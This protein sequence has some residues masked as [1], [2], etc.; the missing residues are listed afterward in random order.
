MNTEKAYRDIGAA[1]VK[2]VIANNYFPGTIETAI[3]ERPMGRG[4][5][6]YVNNCHVPTALWSFP[7]LELIKKIAWH[8]RY[9]EREEKLVKEQKRKAKIRTGV[10]FLRSLK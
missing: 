1:V 2:A 8:V 5:A 4:I 6:F 7:Q 10:D 3:L 9:R